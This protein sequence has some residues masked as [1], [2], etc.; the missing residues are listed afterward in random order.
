M[1]KEQFQ[2]ARQ[3]H[4]KALRR[5]AILSVARDMLKDGD[6]DVVTLNQLA[7]QVGLAK[8]NVIRYF[9]TREAI[10]MQILQEDIKDWVDAQIAQLDDFRDGS[11]QLH[12]L[13]DIL[14]AVTVE[15]PRLC[16]LASV[17]A[18][19]LERNVLVQTAIAFKKAN[20]VEVSRLI[21]AMSKAVP[22]FTPAMHG[23]LVKLQ[24]SLVAGLWQHANPTATMLEVLKEPELRKSHESFEKSLRRGTWLIASGLSAEADK[25]SQ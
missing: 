7:K 16:L 17:V 25:A 2:R 18:R 12:E 24:G 1:V 4:Q 14:V 22:V 3:P 6:L 10:L 23:E 21:I 15:R 8:S 11:T 13:V 9:E 5:E 19:I 20:M